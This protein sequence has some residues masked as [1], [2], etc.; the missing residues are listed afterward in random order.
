M[1]NAENVIRSSAENSSSGM[2]EVPNKSKNVAN[3]RGNR[4]EK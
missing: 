2:D 4:L 1:Y 3:F